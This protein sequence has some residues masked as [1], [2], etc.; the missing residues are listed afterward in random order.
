[1]VNGGIKL[2]HLQILHAAGLL[3]QQAL[4]LFLYV[5]FLLSDLDAGVLSLEAK[6]PGEGVVLIPPFWTFPAKGGR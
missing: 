5:C 1:M 4:P 6:A 3:K 2:F